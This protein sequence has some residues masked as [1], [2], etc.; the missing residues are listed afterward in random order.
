MNRLCALFLTVSLLFAGPALASDG[1]D[2]KPYVSAQRSLSVNRSLLAKAEA[3]YEQLTKEQAEKP[4]NEHAE[5]LDKLL[6][7]IKA[8]R[9]D[10]ERLQSEMPKSTRAAEFLK[11]LLGGA[12][13]DVEREKKLNEKLESVYAL[14]EKALNLVSQKRYQEACEVYEN[15][16]FESADD[17]EAYLLLGHTRLL[18]GE[19]DKARDAFL[20]AMDIDPA[21]RDEI[22]RFYENILVENPQDD[23]AYSHLGFVYWMLGRSEDAK[24][25]FGAALQINPGNLEAKTALDRILA[26]Q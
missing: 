21:N 25:S 20:N 9:E 8:L 6:Y 23:D 3:E 11:D 18:S 17:D 2:S 1:P 15:I 19:Y 4:T 14:H 12:P 5:E 24:N 10:A 22:P 16:T 26:A 13:V 7:Q